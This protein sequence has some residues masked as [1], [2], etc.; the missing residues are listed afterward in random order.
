MSDGAEIPGLPKDAPAA[1]RFVA[2]YEAET[3]FWE[4]VEARWMVAGDDER[5][6]LGPASR[7]IEYGALPGSNSLKVTWQ[8]GSAILVSWLGT[9]DETWDYIDN[10]PR[11]RGYRFGED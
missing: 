6:A 5:I 1:D 11:I 3:S 8:D 4:D 9:E 7:T 10:F 2:R